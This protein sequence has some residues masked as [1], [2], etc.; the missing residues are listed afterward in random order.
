[1]ADVTDFNLVIYYRERKR[2][3]SDGQGWGLG[4]VL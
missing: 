2:V 1:M 4:F 3:F